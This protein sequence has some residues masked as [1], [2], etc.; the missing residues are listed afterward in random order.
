MESSASHGHESAHLVLSTCP[1]QGLPK[2]KRY[3]ADQVSLQLLCFESLKSIEMFFLFKL[4]PFFLLLLG[5]GNLVLSLWTRM[6][7]FYY[8]FLS[9]GKIENLLMPLESQ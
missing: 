8:N 5:K 9:G 2:D 1:P 6:L 7:G 3:L 4:L